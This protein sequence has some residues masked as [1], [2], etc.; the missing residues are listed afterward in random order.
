MCVA[1]DLFILLFIFYLKAHEF[2]FL[3]QWYFK[4]KFKPHVIYYVFN[5][6]SLYNIHTN[7]CTYL[8]L[9]VYYYYYDYYRLYPTLV[10]IILHIKYK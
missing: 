7:S 5:L 8:L 6:D 1:Q 2:F 10:S 9:L 3:K 4:N